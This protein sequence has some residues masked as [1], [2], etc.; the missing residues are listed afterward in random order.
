MEKNNAINARGGARYDANVEKMPVGEREGAKPFVGKKP[1]LVTAI[2]T[3]FRVSRLL[4]GFVFM[5][6]SALLNFIPVLSLE[7]LGLFFEKGVPRYIG[8]ELG[9]SGGAVCRQAVQGGV[10]ACGARIF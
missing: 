7:D 2:V 4:L 1:G 8:G 6:T 9:S 5:L 10:V 3:T